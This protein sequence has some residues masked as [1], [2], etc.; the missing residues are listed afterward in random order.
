MD[1]LSTVRKSLLDKDTEVSQ[2]RLQLHDASAK[3][4]VVKVCCMLGHFFCKSY[5]QQ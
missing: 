5:V 2:L 3:I 4:I 1:E